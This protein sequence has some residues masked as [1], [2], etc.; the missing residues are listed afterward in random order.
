MKMMLGLVAVVWCRNV[1]KGSFE[2]GGSFD[3]GS[4]VGHGSTFLDAKGG[5]PRG[6][7]GADETH[8][9]GGFGV[10]DFAVLI[11]MK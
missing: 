10:L 7:D 9:G 4:D 1:G 11:A 5:L 8:G 3:D 2:N 6:S